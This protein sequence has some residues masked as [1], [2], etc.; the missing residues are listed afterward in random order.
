MRIALLFM[1]LVALSTG[2]CGTSPAP[3]TPSY[4]LQVSRGTAA[5]QRGAE[6]IPVA[7]GSP[8]PAQV[9]DVITTGPDAQAVLSAG[10]QLHVLGAQASLRVD[11]AQPAG[12]GEGLSAVTVV[13][14]LVNF[15]IP[16]KARPQQFQASTST[17]AAIV[18]GTIFSLEA[19]GDETFVTVF[20]GQVDVQAAPSGQALRSLTVD[21]RVRVAGGAAADAPLDPVAAA[22]AKSELLSLLGSLK[23]EISQF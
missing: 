19:R 9:G 7:P 11:R 3:T 4:R 13:S 2:G 5:I 1:I 10:D 16:V 8:V 23:A 12:T 15:L 18:K 6:S 14:G 20:R 21:Q 22:T 17:V